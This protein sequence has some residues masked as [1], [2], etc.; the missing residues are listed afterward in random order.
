MNVKEKKK[1]LAD[2]KFG[3]SALPEN[4]DEEE[5]DS[6]DSDDDM[7][8]NLETRDDLHSR[9]QLYLVLT[10]QYCVALFFV[11]LIF[12]AVMATTYILSVEM[13]QANVRTKL[14][15]EVRFLTWRIGYVSQMMSWNDVMTYENIRDLRKIVSEDH[16]E[17]FEFKDGFMFGSEVHNLD[18]SA[19]EKNIREE[20]FEHKFLNDT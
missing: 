17:I 3:L 19:V 7:I 8:D 2:K 4:G 6:D 15:S 14:S 11:A 18:Y 9:A 20:L 1:K 5:G 16:K 13:Q 10:G 12:I